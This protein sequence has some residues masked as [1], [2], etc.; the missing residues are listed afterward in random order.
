MIFSNF[1]FQIIIVVFVRPFV[2][3]IPNFFPIS[4]LFFS[5]F[6]P[7]FFRPFSRFVPIFSDS[8]I[9]VFVRLFA[10]EVPGV[11]REV[12]RDGDDDQL[13]PEGLLPQA[14]NEPIGGRPVC[15]VAGSPQVDHVRTNWCCSQTSK[16]I[17]ILKYESNLFKDTVQMRK[18]CS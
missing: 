4:L 13:P 14:G 17:M 5:D 10:A 3:E 8:N 2:A 11:R 6:I 16:P 18:F 7:I 15:R 1:F 12:G 9:V